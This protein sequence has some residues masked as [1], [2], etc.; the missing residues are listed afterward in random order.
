MRARLAG[1][2]AVAIVTLW[3]SAAFADAIVITGGHA[4]ANWDGSPTSFDLLGAGTDLM[5][6]AGAGWGFTASGNT[7]TPHMSVFAQGNLPRTE[8]VDGVGYANVFLTGSADFFAGTITLPPVVPNT[9]TTFTTAMNMV[10]RLTGYSNAAH[11]GA[12]LFSIVVTGSGSL[13]IGPV[14]G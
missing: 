4:G 10:G 1:L 8:I 7:I 11:T 14:R 12:P 3:S 6:D 9:T 5:D 13:N 2:A